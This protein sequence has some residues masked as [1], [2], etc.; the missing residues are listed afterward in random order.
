M[1]GNDIFQW[2]GLG[3]QRPDFS[4]FDVSNK[5][6]ENNII[7]EGAAEKGE[8]FQVECSD[9]KFDNRTCNGARHRVATTPFQGV[10]Q[11]LKLSSRDKVDDDIH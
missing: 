7:L 3:D 2:I 4:P 8:I 1:C 10:D 6:V 5:I 11:F 9:I